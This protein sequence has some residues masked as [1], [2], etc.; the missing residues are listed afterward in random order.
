MVS[1]SYS[2]L[3]EFMNSLPNSRVGSFVFLDA[4]SSVAQYNPRKKPS[5]SRD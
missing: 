1:D 4:V 3:K 5:I 2:L